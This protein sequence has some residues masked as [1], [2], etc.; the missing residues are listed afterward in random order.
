[1]GVG[2]LAAKSLLTI[3]SCWSSGLEMTL[4]D[5]LVLLHD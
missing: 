5:D 3:R 4:V 1:M 2:G